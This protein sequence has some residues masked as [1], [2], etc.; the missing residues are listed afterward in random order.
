MA[1]HNRIVGEASTQCVL[2]WDLKSTVLVL[3][4]IGRNDW[5]IIQTV[6]GNMPAQHVEPFVRIHPYAHA[7]PERDCTS[8]WRQ[9][10]VEEGVSQRQIS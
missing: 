2:Y 1:D 4:R 7:E 9:L 8:Y 3:S 5:E 10:G 6:T